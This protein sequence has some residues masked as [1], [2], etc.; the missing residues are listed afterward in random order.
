MSLELNK[1]D[2]N[3][4]ILVFLGLMKSHNLYLD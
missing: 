1:V 3:L 2:K 4:I